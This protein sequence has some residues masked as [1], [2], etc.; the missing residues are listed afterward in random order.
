M[1]ETMGS[2]SKQAITVHSSE[3]KLSYLSQGLKTPWKIMLSLL[4]CNL[5]NSSNIIIIGLATGFV[6]L[7]QCIEC[8]F[9]CSNKFRLIVTTGKHK[10]G[11]N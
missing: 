9:Y 8:H 6:S 3:D 11:I 1:S 5:K 7:L 4:R 2:L 10:N